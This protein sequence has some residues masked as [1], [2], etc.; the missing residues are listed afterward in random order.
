MPKCVGK[1]YHFSPRVRVRAVLAPSPKVTKPAN[2]TPI[3]RWQ[4]LRCSQE[5]PNRNHHCV[6]AFAGSSPVRKKG[7]NCKPCHV[8]LV[9]DAYHKRAKKGH[10]LVVGAD[11]DHKISQDKGTLNAAVFSP[12]PRPDVKPLVTTKPSARRIPVAS[13]RR[14]GRKQK[15]IMSRRIG[16][17]RAGDQLLIDTRIRVR[18]KHLGYNALLQSQ[19]VLSEKPGSIKRKGLPTKVAS[20]KGIITAQNGF[21]CT[22]GKSGHRSPCT[23]RKLGVVRISRDARKRFRKG[24]GPFV[25]LYVNLVMASKAEYGGHRHRKGDVAK[26]AKRGLMSVTHYGAKFRR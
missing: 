11:Q 4:N 15:V 18:T 23:I 20:A 1:I 2:Y 17:L 21:N 26:V 5:L 8:N 9:I 6:I 14:A 7:L 12:G 25:P 22:R 10:V 13:Q 19:L 16:E 3:T 24:T